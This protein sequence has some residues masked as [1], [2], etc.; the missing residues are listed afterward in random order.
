MTAVSRIVLILF[1][2]GLLLFATPA[3]AQEGIEPLVRFEHL[4][5]A[6]GLVSNGVV[7]SLQDSR[8]FLWFGTVGGLS[9]YDGYTFKTYVHERDNPNSL[10]NNYVTSIVEDPSDGTLWLTTNGGVTQFDPATETFTPFDLPEGDRQF[11]TTFIDSR[12]DYWFGGGARTG[13]VRYRPKITQ[14]T[15][16][17]LDR[18]PTGTDSAASGGVHEIVE[19]ADGTLWMAAESHL[20]A[21]D[22]TAE[23]VRHYTLPNRDNRLMS[24]RLGADETLWLGAS[25]G[26]YQF[27]IAGET[28]ETFETF[29]NVRVLHL[30]AEGQLWFSVRLN[31]LVVFD[32]QTAQ[33]IATHQPRIEWAGS[34][35]N[36]RIGTL[37]VDQSGVFWVG[38]R[39]GV[40]RLDPQHAQFTWYGYTPTED[41]PLSHPTVTALHGVVRDRWWIATSQALTK[42]DLSADTTT[43]L[44]AIEQLDGVT[45]SIFQAADGDVWLNKDNRLLQID[46][47]TQG[48]ERFA[49]PPIPDERRLVRNRP[50]I[51]ADITEMTDG[52]LYVAVFGRGVL[53]I[54]PSR[55]TSQWLPHARDLTLAETRGVGNMV[56]ALHRR[57]D[58]TLWVAYERPI[59]THIDPQ[60]GRAENFQLP[61]SLELGNDFETFDLYEDALGIVWLATNS[62]LL[63]LEPQSGE[64]ERIDGLP[65]D[66]IVSIAADGGGNLWLGSTHGLLRYRLDDGAVTQFGI[67][68]GLPS[69]N[70]TVRAADSTPDGR[71]LFGTDNGLVAFYAE[72]IRPKATPPTP[73]LTDLHLFNRPIAIGDER[74]PQ[75]VWATE[76]IELPHD[77]NS[78]TFEFAARGYTDHDNLRYRYRLNGLETAWTEVGSDRHFVTFGQ[79]PPRN[80][81][82]ELQTGTRYGE[83]NEQ[84]AVLSISIMPTWWQR[85]FV[86]IG[87]IALL[88]GVIG[89]SLWWRSVQLKRRNT[90][91]EGV[92]AERTHEL[93]DSEA[94]FRGIAAASFE[95]I[96]VHEGGKIIDANDVVADLFDI[97]TEQLIGL[98]IID[99]GIDN[100]TSDDEVWEAETIMRD[101]RPVVLEGRSG[102]VPYRDR[103]VRVVAL[104]DVTERREREVERQRIAALEERERIGRDLHDDLGQVMGYLNMQ[105]QTAKQQ[106][107]ASHNEQVAAT[108]Q[109]L[110]TVSR[111]AH[112]N[113][114][115]YILGIRTDKPLNLHDALQLLAQ[116]MR[117]R[118]ALT[119]NLV[120][121]HDLTETSIADEVEAQLLRIVQEALINCVKHANVTQVQVVVTIEEIQV[122]VVIDD[123]GV[124]FAEQP[125]IE[126][127]Y[128]LT[129][130]RERAE[131]VGGSLTIHSIAGQGTQVVALLPHLDAAGWSSDPLRSAET[132]RDVRALV[133]DDHPLYLDG[134][135]NL[136]MTHNVNVVGIAH[137]GVTAAEIALRLKPDL[138]LMDIDMPAQDGIETTRQINAALP[139]TKI[140]MLT[141][142]ADEARLLAALRNGASGY[143]LKSLEKN[144]FFAALADVMRGETVLSPTMAAQVL[145]D[146]ARGEGGGE[147]SAENHIELTVRQQEVLRL[148]ASGMSNKEIAA[149]LF[150]S[151]H[152]VKY[153]IRKIFERLQ[154]DN[155]Q[156]LTRYAEEMGIVV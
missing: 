14:R 91:L 71:L 60:N 101:G 8:G 69:L 105:A 149:E 134:L 35:G 49:L 80:Y 33:I 47:Q 59:L 3:A 72:Q 27:D 30:S 50:N 9:R 85:S 110:A 46:A 112:N 115:R 109:Q 84:S 37:T 94:R 135:R 61:R 124:G 95:A 25:R 108:L 146:I 76:Q 106:L 18:R 96:L 19:S 154:L 40:S 113:I 82:F 54:D 144:R 68:D 6:D 111:E 21:Y 132:L 45:L 58:D 48:V 23:Q 88:V 1:A 64:V 70:F 130:M 116:R 153:H 102:T 89:F 100:A 90:E 56:T 74:L 145:A 24:L 92:V 136:L 15:Q 126:G 140:V 34:I 17:P 114:R 117:E 43:P 121:P 104:R 62:G 26:L 79:L 53:Q 20:V 93:A 120:L 99:L 12:G 4:T 119:V 133:V 141:V 137:D 86:Q 77:E 139:E 10:P 13:L 128:G 22:P 51:I 7:S 83:W 138:I 36:G 5:V 148:V 147:E 73:I 28:F 42:F 151:V 44:E 143:L 118:H 131:S 103:T 142:A 11:F 63:R 155:R 125:S 78:L 29:E 122:R 152:T 39:S 66:M 75:A 67:E 2:F 87:A 32:T 41:S 129:I 57:V 127:H 38:T 52:S 55:T 65:T 81:I 123:Q 107:N 31:G 150:L 98:T 156:Q 97:P 16:I